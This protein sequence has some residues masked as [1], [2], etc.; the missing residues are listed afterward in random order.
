MT[1]KE[2][3]GALKV[4][5]ERLGWSQNDVV[6][7]S[8]GKVTQPALSRIEKTGT[9]SIE[10]LVAAAGILEMEILLRRRHDG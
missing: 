2:L 3:G 7:E 6:A 5:R 4:R 1:A 9:G 10:A 8:D